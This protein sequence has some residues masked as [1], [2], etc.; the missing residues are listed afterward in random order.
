M[1]KTTKILAVIL[2]AVLMLSFTSC[3]SVPQNQSETVKISEIKEDGLKKL[4]TQLNKKK[5]IPDEGTVMQSNVIG[6]KEGC[7]FII[8]LDGGNA[9]LELYDY[10]DG[11][12]DETAK[13]VISDTKKNGKFNMLGISDVTAELSDNENYL[14]IYTDPK[15]EGDNPDAGHKKRRSDITKIF[16]KAE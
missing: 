11:N 7:R 13:K 10:G 1:K 2:A 14:M 6:A 5:L 15:S 3:A 16:E 8:T 4:C 12:L 9:L